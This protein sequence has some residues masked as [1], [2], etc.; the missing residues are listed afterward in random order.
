MRGNCSPKI[1]MIPY[2]FLELQKKTKCDIDKNDV[3]FKFHLI[4]GKSCNCRKKTIKTSWSNDTWIYMLIWASLHCLCI[5][6]E[7]TNSGDWS[8]YTSVT[9]DQWNISQIILKKNAANKIWARPWLKAKW[10]TP[11]W[12]VAKYY[13]ICI[14]HNVSSCKACVSAK[15]KTAGSGLNRLYNVLCLLWNIFHNQHKTLNN[16]YLIV[17]LVRIFMHSIF[18]YVCA[19]LVYFKDDE[20]QCEAGNHDCE[21]TCVNTVGSFRCSCSKKGYKLS[22]DGKTCQGSNTGLYTLLLYWTR[23]FDNDFF[24]LPLILSLLL[25]VAW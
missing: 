14:F 10:H 22:D 19:W 4:L 21:D 3:N 20:D 16:L 7:I 5:R 12:N 13:I 24:Q 2:L 6:V 18:I 9:C 1:S 23:P 25:H 11:K 15:Q 8:A 17:T